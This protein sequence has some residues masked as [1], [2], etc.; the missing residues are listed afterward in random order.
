MFNVNKIDE[1][2]LIA[3]D[4]ETYDPNIKTLGP[5]WAPKDGHI[6]GIA[7]AARE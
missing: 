6:I 5:G 4:T 3:I 7:V 2:K 1:A